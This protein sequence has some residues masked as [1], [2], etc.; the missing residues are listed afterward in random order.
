LNFITVNTIDFRYELD[1][2][3]VQARW[4]RG[5][6]SEQ[7]NENDH[8]GTVF[9]LQHGIVSAV[10]RVEFVSDRNSLVLRGH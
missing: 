2:E 3:G 4:G 7:G 5:C 8:L 10:K 6:T 9:S 1:F